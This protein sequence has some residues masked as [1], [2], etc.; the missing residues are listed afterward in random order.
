[1]QKMSSSK[2]P[3]AG[4]TVDDTLALHPKY[5]TTAT[6]MAILGNE[7]PVKLKTFPGFSLLPF[8]IQHMVWIEALKDHD[9]PGINFVKI[10]NLMW[11]GGRKSNKTRL[12][13]ID[14]YS[15]AAFMANLKRINGV[16]KMAVEQYVRAAIANGEQFRTIEVDGHFGKAEVQLNMNDIVCFD[17]LH[18]PSGMNSGN[19]PTERG[20]IAEQRSF[21]RHRLDTRFN[22]TPQWD[23]IRRI[24][25]AYPVNFHIDYCSEPRALG[26]SNDDHQDCLYSMAA[27]LSA[28]RS[29]EEFFLILKGEPKPTGQ[30]PCKLLTKIADFL[31]RGENKSWT[32]LLARCEKF[33]EAI[34]SD[35]EIVEDDDEP[36]KFPLDRRPHTVSTSL[37]G[38][39]AADSQLLPDPSLKV[40]HG[41]SGELHYYQ[42][43]LSYLGMVG[44]A[45][46]DLRHLALWVNNRDEHRVKHRGFAPRAKDIEYKLMSYTE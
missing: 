16:S 13:R 37:R 12:Y 2:T 20:A 17:W 33:E 27:N 36:G 19:L 5:D 24:A 22:F 26:C 32:N 42:I 11:R 46:H 38:R 14:N 28:L 3:L 40:F 18:D 23:W 39:S 8:D 29:L 9:Q 44:R 6:S 35:L 31:Y 10:F 45:H 4:D 1:M 21:F 30:N 15:M 41:S 7:K 34:G 25:M 43:R